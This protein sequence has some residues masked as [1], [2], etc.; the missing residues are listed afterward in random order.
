MAAAGNMNRDAVIRELKES[1]DIWDVIVVGGGATGLGVALESVARGYRTLLLEQHDF[2]KATSSRST[3]L[4]HGGVRYLQQGNVSLVMEALRER[5]RLLKNAPHICHNLPFVVPVY[6]WWDG[7]FYGV[8]MKLYDMLA[9]KLGLGPSKVL[10]REKTLELLPNVEPKGLKN[11]VIYHDGQFDDARLAVS[12]AQTIA[13]KG[14][15]VLNYCKVTGFKKRGGF[16][17]GVSAHDEETGEDYELDARVVINATGIFSDD[18][19]QMDD[20]SEEPL[21]APSQG[22]HLVLDKSFLPGESA[23]M[24]P[25]TADG[26]VLFAVPWHG[27]TVVGTTDTAI[28]KSTLEPKPQKEEIDFLLEHAAIYLDR[29]PTREDVLSMYCGI[30]PLVR[31]PGDKGTAALARDHVLMISDSNLVSITG[32]KWT[33]YRKMAEDTID[34]AALVGGLEERPSGTT[35]LRLHGWIKTPM[36]TDGLLSLYG[37][38]GTGVRKTMSEQPGWDEPLHPNLPYYW[39]EVAWGVRREMARTVEDVLSRRTRSLLLDAR[40]SV[41]AAPKVAA[42]MAAEL[43]RDEAWQKAQV[44][45]FTALARDYM[46]PTT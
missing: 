36:E 17:T 32:G 41:E 16:I 27:R 2:A 25:K 38:D 45:E 21:M 22:V 11:G 12:L 43:G 31:S 10:S 5:G 30:R 9:G 7:P 1:Y 37:S 39:G 46:I 44:E 3:K 40:A 13:D 29:D 33:T 6:E 26:R 18:T 14:G 42:I 28:E 20:P 19:R 15:H 24:V 4:V 23:I 35:N 8:G 34:A